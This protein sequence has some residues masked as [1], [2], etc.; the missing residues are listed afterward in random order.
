M[1]TII[2]KQYHFNTTWPPAPV[3]AVVTRGVSPSRRRRRKF[4]VLDNEILLLFAEY[5]QVKV[6][7]DDVQN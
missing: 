2:V 3:V 5:L 6:N 1:P 4:F 7:R